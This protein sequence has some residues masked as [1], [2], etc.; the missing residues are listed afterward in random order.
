ML[1]SLSPIKRDGNK[2]ICQLEGD[3][4]KKTDLNNKRQTKEK[5]FFLKRHQTGTHNNQRQML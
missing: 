3:D 1:V 2:E 4:I 5:V